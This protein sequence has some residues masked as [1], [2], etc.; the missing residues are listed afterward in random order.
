[1]IIRELTNRGI[2][3]RAIL[4]LCLAVLFTAIAVCFWTPAGPAQ[5]GPLSKNANLSSLGISTGSLSPA[6]ATNTTAYTASSNNPVANVLPT[7]EESHAT[8]TVNGAPVNSVSWSPGV[9][10]NPGPNTITIQVT[11]Q[12]GATTKTYTITVTGPAA[13]PASSDA[14]LSSLDLTT[15]S[16]SPAFAPGKI[17]YT[18]N[19]DNATASTKVR[20]IT[21]ESHATIT[22]NGTLVTSGNWSDIPL[23][24]GDNTIS[25]A[26]T[27]QDGV[28]TRTYSIIV[29]RQ[30]AAQPPVQAGQTV[31]RYYIGGSDYYVNDQ[32][33]S[34]DIAPIIKDDRTLLPIRYVAEPLGA[35]VDWNPAGQKVTVTMNGKTIELWIDKNTARVNGI[36]KSIDPN[37][38]NVAAIVVPPGRTMLPL[39]FIV[40]NLGCLV[41]WNQTLQEVKVTYSKP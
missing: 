26:V 30:A 22:V 18:Q 25:V 13:P 38:P 34:M 4:C 7:A 9:P 24:V 5:A 2:G 15:G 21:K 23:S 40:E 6:F 12:D 33:K 20:P 41:D 8:I 27:A 3:G 17:S 16:L 31:L 29:T 1:M 11:A 37:S 39:R 32:I 28:T 19:A 36:D 35:S 10:L 14:N